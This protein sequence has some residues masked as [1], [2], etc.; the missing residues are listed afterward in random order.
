MVVEVGG[1]YLVPSMVEEVRI[2]TLR[3]AVLNQ[4]SI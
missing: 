3:C 2:N 4:I 1:L